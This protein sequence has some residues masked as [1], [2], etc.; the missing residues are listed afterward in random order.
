MYISFVLL[1]FVFVMLIYISYYVFH[2]VIKSEDKTQIG[3]S[4]SPGLH[5]EDFFFSF[6]NDLNKS[7]ILILIV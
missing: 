7:H 2:I 1:S 3:V 5:F 4:F 6:S